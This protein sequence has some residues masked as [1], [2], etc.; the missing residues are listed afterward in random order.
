MAENDQHLKHGKAL[1]GKVFG[2][3]VETFNSLV[4]FRLGLRGDA[5][6]K[7]GEGHVTY[8]RE[9]NI[10][11]CDGCDGGNGGGV[12]ANEKS[13]LK[14]NK[15]EIDISGRK[16]DDTF[17]IHTLTVKGGDGE[18]GAKDYKIFSAED[19]E[20]DVSKDLDDKIDEKIDEK[21]KDL[22]RVESLNGETGE[23]E[24]AGG[25]KVNVSTNGKT[26]TISLDEAKEDPEP[27]PNSNCDD[28]PGSEELGGVLA[29]DGW[30]LGGGGGGAP[31][32]DG[33]GSSGVGCD[34]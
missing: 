1:C 22:K 18:D 27:D 31:A 32:E 6:G 2:R 14:V 19:I 16:K 5:E 33:T 7:N 13:G 10:I 29:W 24:I 8:D 34:C 23:L 28:H 3:F 30:G 12:T 15:G 11:R 25:H 9:N 26:I 17:G 21:L 4:D 20:I